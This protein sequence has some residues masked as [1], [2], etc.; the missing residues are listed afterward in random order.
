MSVQEIAASVS[1]TQSCSAFNEVISC[2][3]QDQLGEPSDLH[4]GTDQL[5]D[6]VGVSV[7]E[8]AKTVARSTNDCTPRNA[9]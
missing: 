2:M 7:K 9:K 3:T 5:P 1:S 4:L 6:I 8:F